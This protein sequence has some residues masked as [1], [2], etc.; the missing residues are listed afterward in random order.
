LPGVRPA[1]KRFK[2]IFETAVF[3]RIKKEGAYDQGVA[4]D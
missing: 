1:N 2:L 4:V 3:F